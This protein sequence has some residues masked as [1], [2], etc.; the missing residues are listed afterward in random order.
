MKQI[1]ILIPTLPVRI[2]KY[3]KLVKE[4]NRQVVEADLINQVQIVSFCDTK[5]YIV[6]HKRNIL[7]NLSLAK[8]ICYMDDDDMIASDFIEK[9]YK[10][11][12]QDMDCV[13]FNGRFITDQHTRVF[14][15]SIKHRHDYDSPDVFYRIPNHLAL[16]KREIAL[17]CPFPKLQ[18][19]EDSEYAKNL[20]K[21]LKT[22]VKIEEILYFYHYNQT[23]S[24]TN[25]NSLAN[26]Y[27]EKK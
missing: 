10:A 14:N 12:L 6:G 26:Q 19:G 21:H 8:Y 18:H 4:I 17:K 2:D 7:M 5:D 27:Q 15:M 1:A 24:Q 3:A 23:T 22:E 16:V 13:T 9:L 25:P 20:Q 11:S